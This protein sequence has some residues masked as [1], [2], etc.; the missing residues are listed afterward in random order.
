MGWS[1]EQVPEAE[2][3]SSGFGWLLKI[4]KVIDGYS[5]AE[6]KRRQ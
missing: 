1:P 6:N 4:H 3:D 5:Q 2:T